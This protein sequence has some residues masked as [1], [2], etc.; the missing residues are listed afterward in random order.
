MVCGCRLQRLL[1][2]EPGT[3]TDGDLA[4]WMQPLL[5]MAADAA[6]AAAAAAADAMPGLSPYA[7]AMDEPLADG[8]STSSSGVMGLAAGADDL[9]VAD[10]AMTTLTTAM[11]AGGPLVQVQTCPRFYFL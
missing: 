7:T 4:T 5:F 11:A 2:T 1:L 9:A 6:A 10:S 3:V 8:S